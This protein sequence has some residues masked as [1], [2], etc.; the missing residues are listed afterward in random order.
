MVNDE[1]LLVDVMRKKG[2]PDLTG[3]DLPQVL[4]L[5]FC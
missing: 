5:V 4:R 3:L 1:S 2:N